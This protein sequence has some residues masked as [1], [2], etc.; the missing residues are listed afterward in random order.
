MIKVNESIYETICTLFVKQDHFF[1]NNPNRRPKMFLFLY[2]YA[3]FLY[4]SW[5]NMKG[6][7]GVKSRVRRVKQHFNTHF[8]RALD[9]YEVH[10]LVEYGRRDAKTLDRQWDRDSHAK[11][12]CTTLSGCAHK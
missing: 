3:E 11:C 2:F 8:C 1:Y 4:S 7:E 10:G 5:K 12:I 9:H 6:E